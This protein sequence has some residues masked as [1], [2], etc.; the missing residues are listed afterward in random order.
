MLFILTTGGLFL[1]LYKFLCDFDFFTETEE[2]LLS[3]IF[4]GLY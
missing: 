2:A 3:P 1:F 4:L